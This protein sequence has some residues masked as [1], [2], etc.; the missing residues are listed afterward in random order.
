MKQRLI[1]IAWLLGMVAPGFSQ[2][3]PSQ[4]PP[5][6]LAT[7][8]QSVIETDA[9][10]QWD[11]W[12]LKERINNQLIG[13]LKFKKHLPDSVPVGIIRSGDRKIFLLLERAPSKTETFDYALYL[14]EEGRILAVDVLIYREPQGSEIDFPAFRK[15]FVGKNNP[16]KIIP[17][18]TIQVISGATISSRSITYSVR[19]LLVIFQK[20]H[21]KG[22][23]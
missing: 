19:D 15:Q 14:S 13:Q 1:I 21:R 10:V 20:L 4:I 5:Q 16:R 18:R 22:E 9:P 17:G 3:S 2:L 7:S 8:L 23:E 6:V 12:P 11:Y